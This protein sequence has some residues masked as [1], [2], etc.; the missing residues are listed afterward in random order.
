MMSFHKRKKKQQLNTS[1][2]GS[3]D[4][5]TN[6]TGSSCNNNNNN[7]KTKTISLPIASEF[8]VI[9]TS[10]SGI[11]NHSNVNQDIN[12]KLNGDDKQTATNS[13][14]PP[15]SQPLTF[16]DSEMILINKISICDNIVKD[17]D[18]KRIEPKKE[19]TNMIGNNQKDSMLT[20]VPDDHLNSMTT[21]NTPSTNAKLSSA[22]RKL[23]ILTR[24]FRPW[25]W[26]RKPNKAASV[27]TNDET[28][29]SIGEIRADCQSNQSSQ[30]MLIPL[31]SMSYLK[32]A[33]ATPLAALAKNP[34]HNQQLMSI[35]NRRQQ[36]QAIANE[37]SSDSTDSSKIYNSNNNSPN[38]NKFQT[39]ESTQPNSNVNNSTTNEMIKIDG[40]KI[41][42][43]ITSTLPTK[44]T[45]MIPTSSTTICIPATSSSSSIKCNM[46]ES[47]AANHQKSKNYLIHCNS[48]SNNNCHNSHNNNQIHPIESI[49]PVTISSIHFEDDV[50]PIPPPRMFS[51]SIVSALH[52]AESMSN[53]PECETKAIENGVNNKTIGDVNFDQDTFNIQQNQMDFIHNNYSDGLIESFLNYIMNMDSLD[54][55]T[56]KQNPADDDKDEFDFDEWNSPLV[57][58]VP[59]K[60]PQF[61]AIPKKSA[62]KK[63]K[64]FAAANGQTANNNNY[65]DNND[66]N[67]NASKPIVNTTKT[68]TATTPTETTNKNN[69]KSSTF[70]TNIPNG[71]VLSKIRQFDL[72]ANSFNETAKLH[73]AKIQ[74]MPSITLTN[75][76][77]KSVN[78]STT[79]VNGD[80]SVSSDVNLKDYYGDDEKGKI[81]A[82][83]ARKESLQ[84]KLSQRPDKQELI[85]KN[86]IQ[87][88]SDNEKQ[89]SREAIGTKLNRRLSLRPTP[90]ELEQRNIL[91]QQSPDEIW[92]EKENKKQTLIR[93]LSFRP[94]IDE[95][96]ERKIIRFNDY[97]EVTQANDYD[98]RAD[99]PWTRLTP[100]DKAAI[101]KELNEFK[102]SEMEV[103]E[104]SRHMTS[105]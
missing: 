23:L 105:K 33:V 25:R 13:S 39:L 4:I 103:H 16:T 88:M 92:K 17:V 77:M 76:E 57:E 8:V 50:G 68:I 42:K 45:I 43:V 60:Q 86:I 80:D 7:N 59:V 85:D 104:D 14:T 70:T 3:D 52:T 102:S 35:I 101:R 99:K 82:K 91:K 61:T 89:D 84:L 28:N 20:S 41:E 6:I 58:E 95:L 47:S 93:K 19:S 54:D 72:N 11:Y 36:Q 83:L 81:A 27:A 2:I 31:T 66:D 46:I 90:E 75:S 97:V 94:T 18:N 65:N 24:L 74:I 29:K 55:G 44:S 48:S 1:I 71:S 38:N 96:K 22:K 30:M 63:P 32:G 79:N 15:S 62:L 49:S 40:F 78:I 98:R 56:C 73:V 51:D 26:K 69:H 67:V 9:D 21:A 12:N 53:G 100:K 10:L 34:E 37:K 87:T 5:I 64:D